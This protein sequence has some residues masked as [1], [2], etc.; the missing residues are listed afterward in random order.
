[1]E[2]VHATGEVAHPL[3][4][5]DQRVFLYVGWEDYERVLAMRGESSG[6]RLTYLRGVLELM[7]PSRT[8]GRIKK[9]F[10]RLVEAWAE[11]TDTPLN[12]FGSW[13]VKDERADRGAEPDECYVVGDRETKA[14][15]IAIEVIWTSGGLDKLE[16][17]RKLGARE[18][19]LWRDDRIEIHALRGER[20]EQVPRSEL[21]PALD[22]EH[23]AH[24]LNEP[25]QTRAVRRYR[26]ELRGSQR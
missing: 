11:E 5:P 13:T 14:P 19:W 21:L 6:V 16:V 24:F 25:D 10:A 18:V 4:D 22:F 26:K 7:T 9:T 17:W 1:M 2:A 20:F 15:D 23:L 12:G 8:H 3:A